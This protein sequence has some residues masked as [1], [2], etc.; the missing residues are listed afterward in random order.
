MYLK[1]QNVTTNIPVIL[2]TK[3]SVIGICCFGYGGTFSAAPRKATWEQ[4]LNGN[5]KEIPSPL[6]KTKEEKEHLEKILHFQG[7]DT[8]D[9]HVITVFTN[10]ELQIKGISTAH[11]CT[12]DTL[13]PLLVERPYSSDKGIDPQEVGNKL[14]TLQ[15]QDETQKPKKKFG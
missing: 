15:Y 1:N 6:L 9:C 12:K 14:G 8:L 11:Y 13:M 10:P 2:I 3:S 5:R 4:E 7:Y